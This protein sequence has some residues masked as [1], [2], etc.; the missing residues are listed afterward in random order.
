MF[1][2]AY[3]KAIKAR[4]Y[5]NST[6][7]VFTSLYWQHSL[8][9]QRYS[10]GA[11]T[12]IAHMGQLQVPSLQLGGGCQ[13]A[14]VKL[15]QRCVPAGWGTTLFVIITQKHPSPGQEFQ[16]PRPTPCRPAHH[17]TAASNLGH[18]LEALWR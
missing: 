4:D 6:P 9:P 1:A 10:Y 3:A 11:R 5:F 16:A 2:L 8:S 18:K 12:V 15:A 14:A 13:C 17:C 7:T